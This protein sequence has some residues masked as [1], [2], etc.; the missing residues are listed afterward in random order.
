MNFQ[1]QPASQINADGEIRTV[2]A[3]SPTADF[4]AWMETCVK[5]FNDRLPA[6]QKD[7]WAKSLQSPQSPR[8]KGYLE[9]AWNASSP[10]K[11]AA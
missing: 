9:K 4:Q 7:E 2:P 11:A 6:A 8:I 1:T 10:F 3:A 5:E